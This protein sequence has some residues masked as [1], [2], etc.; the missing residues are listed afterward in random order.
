MLALHCAVTES[1]GRPRRLPYVRLY[2]DSALVTTH[3]EAIG[4]FVK[5]LNGK[6]VRKCFAVK[7]RQTDALVWKNATGSRYCCTRR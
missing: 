7:E 2:G 1:T 5:D 3:L 6:L 4:P